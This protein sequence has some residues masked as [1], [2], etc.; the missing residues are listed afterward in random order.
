MFAGCGA[1]ELSLGEVARRDD[2][3][4]DGDDDLE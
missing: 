4:V 3:G 1:D 2:A